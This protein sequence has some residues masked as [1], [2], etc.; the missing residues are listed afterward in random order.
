MKKCNVEYTVKNHLCL[1]C[2]IC[3]EAC[4]THS[5]KMKIVHGEWRPVI[6]ESTCLND[7]GC[8]KCYKVCSGVGLDIKKYADELYAEAECNDRYIG[9]YERLYT[10]WSCDNDIRRTANSGGL[11]SSIL[12]YLL[13]NKYID[14]AVVTRYSAEAPLKTEA[15]IATTPEE[16]LVAKGSKYAPVQLSETLNKVIPGGVD[17]WSLVCLVTYSQLENGQK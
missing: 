3:A 13:D 8:N 6:N 7:K 2:G 15:F 17:L 16:I 14:G 5:I 10:G 12:I 1:G 4:P 9:K 11:V